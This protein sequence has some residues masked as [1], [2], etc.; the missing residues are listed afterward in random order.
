M[1]L[2]LT[3]DSWTVQY[4]TGTGQ[5]NIAYFWQGASEEP[6]FLLNWPDA[7]AAFNACKVDYPFA[8]IWIAPAYKTYTP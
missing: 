7:V 5:G 3:I 1:V 8:R 6:L 4:A 2:G